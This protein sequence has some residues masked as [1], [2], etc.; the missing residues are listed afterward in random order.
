MFR[1]QRQRWQRRRARR[2]TAT[3]GHR[4]HRGRARRRPNSQVVG[5]AQPARVQASHA[6]AGYRTPRKENKLRVK[7]GPLSLASASTKAASCVSSAGL[8]RRLF[9]T[10]GHRLLLLQ[11]LQLGCQRARLLLLPQTGAPGPT[12]SCSGCLLCSCRSPARQAAE[13]S[14]R[15]T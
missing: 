6:A 3:Q 8:R 1:R 11:L 7:N 12:H 2:R 15:H 13:P 5:S 4:R 9:H 14:P 10:G